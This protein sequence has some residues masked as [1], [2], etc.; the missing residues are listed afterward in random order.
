MS[1][2]LHADLLVGYA[3]CGTTAGSHRAPNLQMTQDM[4]RVT[5]KRCINLLAKRVEKRLASGDQDIAWHLEQAV[6]HLRSPIGVENAL[7]EVM[8]SLLPKPRW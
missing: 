5:C 7:V 3:E 2:V 6:Y 4:D 1:R 8:N